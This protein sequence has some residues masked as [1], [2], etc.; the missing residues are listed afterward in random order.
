MIL[1]IISVLF[2]LIVLYKLLTAGLDRD[3][4]WYYIG[5]G[6]VFLMNL[7]RWMDFFAGVRNYAF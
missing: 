7:P 6:L 4:K 5:L 1:L 3:D 2:I